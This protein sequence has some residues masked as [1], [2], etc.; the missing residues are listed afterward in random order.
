VLDVAAILKLHCYNTRHTDAVSAQRRSRQKNLAYQ[1]ALQG[2][3]FITEL[4]TY[5]LLSGYAQ[6]K[7]QAYALT[8]ISWCLVNG[9]DGL[10]VLVCN[11]DFRKQIVKFVAFRERST[12]V[13]SITLRT[14]TN[15][16]Q[17][18]N[19]TRRIDGGE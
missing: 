15:N 10:I 18:S 8:S 13:G 11:R 3:L 14:E 5:F 7:W 6:N 12:N 17:R 4:V 9:M 16:A 19:E 2:I 1:A